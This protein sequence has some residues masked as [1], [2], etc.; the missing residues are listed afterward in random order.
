MITVEQESVNESDR[1][2]TRG[3]KYPDYTEMKELTF[4]P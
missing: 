1:A 3:R 4:V 2:G